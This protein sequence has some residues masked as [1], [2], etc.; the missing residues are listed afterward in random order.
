MRWFCSLPLAPSPLRNVLK[1][2]RGVDHTASPK[3]TTA[4]AL[5]CCAKLRPD[6]PHTQLSRTG[7][8]LIIKPC[9]LNLTMPRLHINVLPSQISS[10][11][12]FWRPSYHHFPFLFDTCRPLVCP[13]LCP[14][15]PPVD[16]LLTLDAPFVGHVLAHVGPSLALCWPLLTLLGHASTLCVSMCDPL[17]TLLT[18]S[19]TLVD[20]TVTRVDPVLPCVD[21]G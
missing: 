6:T 4:C 2:T 18:L 7:K 19:L 14:L 21:M 17:M 5:M 11:R 8:P 12:T 3:H 16:P 9:I 10:S 13:L 1:Y 20:P 15:V